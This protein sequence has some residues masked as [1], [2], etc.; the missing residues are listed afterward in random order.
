MGFSGHSAMPGWYR[1]SWLSSAERDEL[2]LDVIRIPEHH[3]GVSQ[4]LL[5]IP[6]AGVLDAE[7]I[8][9]GRP[10]RQLLAGGHAEGQVVQPRTALIE[11][12]APV[13]LME[14]QPHPDAQARIEKHHAVAAVLFLP[15]VP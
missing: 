6:D 2:K 8:E 12:F 14:V 4:G 11:G 3:R 5:L 1:A 13:G 15:I 9:P 7:L 10:G